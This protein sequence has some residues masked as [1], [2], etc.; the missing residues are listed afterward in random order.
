[1]FKFSSLVLRRTALV[2]VGAASFTA[3]FVFAHAEQ[4]DTTESEQDT[5]RRVLAE[6]LKV[7]RETRE[8]WER[9]EV[10]KFRELP[11]RAWPKDQFDA[12]AVDD[13]FLSLVENE[14]VGD[15]EIDVSKS[16]CQ[17]RAFDLATTLVFNN[18]DPSFGLALYKRL[19]HEGY[20][21]GMVAAGIVLIEGY[22]VQPNEQE[23][24]GWIKRSA[25]AG[26]AQG[27]Y[28]L[29]TV[30]YNGIDGVVEEDEVAAFKHFEAAAKEHHVGSLFMSAEMLLCGEG[31]ERDIERAVPLLAE[32]AENGHRYARQRMRGLFDRAQEREVVG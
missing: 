2:S 16:A 4:R 20:V 25:E 17:K 23:G 5:L 32:A 27:H 8:R 6:H 24:V 29:G 30:L 22:G 12:E 9:D 21:D 13:I 18:V 28:E 7:E 1:M 10:E 19:A 26:S 14:C 11:S 3:K 31:V 15:R